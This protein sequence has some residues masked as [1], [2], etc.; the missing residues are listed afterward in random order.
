MKKSNFNVLLLCSM[1]AL[2]ACGSSGGGSA[3]ANKPVLE[4]ANNDNQKAEEIAK[5]QE[6]AKAEKE[7]KKQEAAAKAEE[8]RKKQ[9]AAKAE[10]E[11]KKQEAAA[12]AE[13]ERKKQEAA[14]KAEEERKKQE[15]AAKAEEERKK[16]EAAAKA[17]EERKKQEAAASDKKSPTTADVVA[18]LD[19]TFVANHK[20]KADF[21]A[22]R[23]INGAVISINNS[24]GAV[25]AKQPDSTELESININGQKMLLLARYADEGKVSRP[26]ND[27]DFPDGGKTGKGFVGSRG[28]GYSPDFADFR[29]GVYTDKGVSTLFVQGNASSYVPS[30]GKFRYSGR[31][32]IGENGEYN[33]VHGVKAVAD[34]ATKR[35]DVSLTPPS[36]EGQ[37]TRDAL[38]FG[39]T[40]KGNTFSGNENGIV[41]KGG[42]YGGGAASAAGVFFATDGKHKG[43]NGAFGVSERT[44]AK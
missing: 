20:E 24:T 35:I 23:P 15:A 9:E 39:A 29:W 18:Q 2:T 34:F 38:E 21:M 42:F 6:A 3:V 17:E 22:Y 40:I 8:E 10:E 37:A 14:A 25:S 26:I 33:Q 11:R 31:A 27:S 4:Q 28:Y 5:A 19:K 44:T 12:K 32:V 41:S 43:L 1:L 7:R 13:E 16:Q 36:R 30:S